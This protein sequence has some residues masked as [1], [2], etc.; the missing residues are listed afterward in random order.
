LAAAG[1]YGLITRNGNRYELT[2]TGLGLI[3]GDAA[4]KNASAQAALM[5]T[6]FGRLIQVLS[7]RNVSEETIAARLQNDLQVPAASAGKLAGVL[8]AAA[9]QAGILTDGRFNATEIEAAVAAL[10]TPPAEP[11]PA[12]STARRPSAGAAGAAT[13]AST[14][15]GKARVKETL[16]DP[17]PPLG[18]ELSSAP[19]LTINVQLNVSHLSVD[20][21][22]QLMEK[23]KG[24]QSGA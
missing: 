14:A 15:E 4:S 21:I 12:H 20:E 24:R 8:V 18:R 6:N 22:V 2:N 13:R 7:G 16:K 23:L 10:P 17:R 5:G 11:L 3:S 19:G 9:E 1:Y